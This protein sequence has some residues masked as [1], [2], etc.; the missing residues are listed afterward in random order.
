ML[1]GLSGVGL[2]DLGTLD[3]L[4]K[5]SAAKI[6]ETSPQ[7]PQKNVEVATTE[8]VFKATSNEQVTTYPQPC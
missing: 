5:S 3:A 1:K 2:M 6:T 8:E 4:K 7:S